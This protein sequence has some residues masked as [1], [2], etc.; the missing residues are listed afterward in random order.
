MLNIKDY[1]DAAERQYCRG[2]NA[3]MAGEDKEKTSLPVRTSSWMRGYEDGQNESG[4]PTVWECVGSCPMQVTDTDTGRKYECSNC[5]RTVWY[6][7]HAHT[8]HP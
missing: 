8:A 4:S 1:K 2:Y 7:V 6:P 5:G 3:A